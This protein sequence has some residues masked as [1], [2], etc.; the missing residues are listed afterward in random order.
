V[1]ALCITASGISGM[2]ALTVGERKHEIGVRL[3]MGATPGSVILSM[4]K[5]V[6][7]LMT[8]G[9]GSGFCAAW[10]MSTSMSHII[11]GIAP[12]DVMTFT[13][14]SALLIAVAAASCFVPLTRITRL[15]PVMLLKAE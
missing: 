4:M 10:L 9:L 7:A 12:R 2:M 15:D 8:I 14:S 1:I 5:Q 11:S 13:T 6:L 3:A